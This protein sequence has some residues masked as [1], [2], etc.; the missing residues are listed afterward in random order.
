MTRHDKLKQAL[1]DAMLKRLEKISLSQ[2]SAMVGVNRSL[3]SK[4]RRGKGHPSLEMLIRVADALDCDVVLQ[5]RKQTRQ[6]TR[7][8]KTA[9]SG[10]PG[11]NGKANGRPSKKKS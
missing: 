4:W 2:F 1:V 11:K 10:K 7:K 3:L 5:D 6:T 8:A 9:R